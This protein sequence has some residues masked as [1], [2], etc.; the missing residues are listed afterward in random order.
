MQGKKRTLMISKAEVEQIIRDNFFDVLRNEI[1]YKYES[2]DTALEKII[3]DNTLMFSKPSTFNDPFDCNEYLLKPQLTEKMLDDALDSLGENLSEEYRKRLKNNLA[4]PERVAS[5]LKDEKEQFKMTCF[6][7]ISDETLMWSHYA[8][9]H[10]GICVGFKFPVE[11][12][13][14]FILCGV[15]Y[16]NEIKPIDGATDFLRTSLY[17]LTTK[18]ERWEY[19]KEVRTITKTIPKNDRQTIEFDSSH[20]KEIIFGC[21]VK[22]SKITESIAR[23]NQS[24]LKDKGIKFSK[25]IIDTNSFLLKKI[26]V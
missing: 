12:Q 23:I 6:S 22:E 13:E 11:N 2:F 24:K 5:I 4:D 16:E 25:M 17:W 20:I 8:D 14:K 1:V 26:A 15:R 10:S 9:K 21:N 3:L 18:S 7:R 19:E